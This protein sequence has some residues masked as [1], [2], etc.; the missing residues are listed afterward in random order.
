MPVT[1]TGLI[2]RKSHL[3]FRKIKCRSPPGRRSCPLATAAS[4]FRYTRISPIPG[5]THCFGTAC[6]TPAARQGC[7]TGLFPNI[8]LPYFGRLLL[9]PEGLHLL[10]RTSLRHMFSVDGSVSFRGITAGGQS[11]GAG[12]LAPWVWAFPYAS[13]HWLALFI[14]LVIGMVQLWSF[15]GSSCLRSY[16]N[17]PADGFGQPA[18]YIFT[19]FARPSFP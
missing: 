18:G 3:P 14:E 6:T 10:I 2:T 13:K 9:R 4:F 15:Q 16:Y 19:D 5:K 1:C 7:F 17:L 11:S 12:I 8:G